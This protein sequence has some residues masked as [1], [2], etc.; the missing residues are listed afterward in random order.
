MTDHKQNERQ[1]PKY[2]VPR[3][4]ALSRN[5]AIIISKVI[6]SSFSFTEQYRA[7]KFLYDERFTEILNKIFSLRIE[8]L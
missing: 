6:P 8:S 7:G 1:R 4:Q 5:I 3:I 2:N